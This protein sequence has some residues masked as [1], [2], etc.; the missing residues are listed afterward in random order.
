MTNDNHRNR[1]AAPT[2]NPEENA[3]IRRV[4]A[5]CAAIA[6]K[7][8]LPM[9][10][11]QG[12]DRAAQLHHQSKLV[13]DEAAWKALR[14]GLGIS[15]PLAP[16]PHP[17]NAVMGI[18]Q[19]F[20]GHRPTSGRSGKLA[21]IL[22]QCDDLDSGCEL[23]AM[24]SEEPELNGLDGLVS[25]VG[26]YFGGVTRS[27]LD[28]AASRVPVFN[29]TAYRAIEM[30]NNEN[31]NLGDV[32]SLVAAD[33]TLAGHIVN[34]ANSA[35][36]RSTTRLK[37]VRKA[38]VRIGVAPARQIIW[39]AA[40]RQLFEAKHSRSLWNHS[41]EVAEAAVNIARRSGLMDCE[42]A[43][44]AGLMHDIGKLVILNLPAAPLVRQERLTH[45]GC[46]DLIVERVLLGEDH[47]VIGARALRHWRFAE[48]IAAAVEHH[49]TPEANTSPLCSI[50]YLAE[51]AV[52]KDTGLDS[53]WRDEL[54]RKSLCLGADDGWLPAAADTVMSGLRF[55]A[56]A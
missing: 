5:W 52:G 17:Y 50:L 18:L 53:A 49:H 34:A 28:R 38:V 37:S 51:L 13:V 14:L 55:A 44:L 32:E 20:Q 24:I 1:G 56:A 8:N 39:A 30:L 10:E 36:L 26:G 11:R 29:A 15:A 23:D 27:D 7:L 43:F 6:E 40:M 25:E 33:Q 2:E 42:Q 46:P 19:A 41:L 31:T 47:A 21:R 35:L 3:H 48:S 45:S 9:A 4:A 22:E 12:L 16:E 54:A